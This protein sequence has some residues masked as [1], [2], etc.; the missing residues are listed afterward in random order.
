M[1]TIEAAFI[2]VFLFK[3]PV[4]DGGGVL[5]TTGIGYVQAITT[6]LLIIF[7]A[8]IIARCIKTYF[9]DITDEEGSN[10]KKRR[11]LIKV[12]VVINIIG[13]FILLMKKYYA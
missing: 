11:N 8:G 13:A 3:F 9:D 5:P 4:S 2:Q 7:N 10:K 1:L 6:A 12:L